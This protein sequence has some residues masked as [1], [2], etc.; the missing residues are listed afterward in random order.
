MC[1]EGIAGRIIGDAG[2]AIIHCLGWA[3]GNCL[4]YNLSVFA[5]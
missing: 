4:E 1:G 5:T 3:K 2:K